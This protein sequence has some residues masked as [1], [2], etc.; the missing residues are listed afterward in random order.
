MEQAA[1]DIVE[2]EMAGYRCFGVIFFKMNSVYA[3]WN[4]LGYLF[5]DLRIALDLKA[6]PT[7]RDGEKS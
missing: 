3:M 6:S 5:N 7:K 4:V 1:C 2:C